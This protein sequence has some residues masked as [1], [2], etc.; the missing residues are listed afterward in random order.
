MLVTTYKDGR[1][2]TGLMIGEAN[3]RR[4]FPKRRS[5]IELRLDDLQIQCTLEPDFWHGRPEI[6][7]PRLSVWLEFKAGRE[8]TTR[9]PMQMSLVPSGVSTYV[10]RPEAKHD[11]VFGAEIM[12][13]A[14]MLAESILA[15]DDESLL[16]VRS[17]A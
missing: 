7:D 3:A 1:T 12:T 17:V 14:K 8:R 9:Q 16:E 4:Y 10:V 13:P 11:E 2:G 6:R 15:I 5:S